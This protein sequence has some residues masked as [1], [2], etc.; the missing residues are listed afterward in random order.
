MSGSR[1]RDLNLAIADREGQISLKPFDVGAAFAIQWRLTDNH[2]RDRALG[3]WPIGVFE[4]LADSL[5][6]T[7]L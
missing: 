4:E 2:E 1:L 5:S 3:A 7:R 6:E